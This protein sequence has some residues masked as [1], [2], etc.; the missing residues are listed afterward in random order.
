MTDSA[1]AIDGYAAALIEIAR[2]EGDV[3]GI[4]DEIYRAASAVA[5]NAELRDTLADPQVP[6][7]RK[8][9]IVEDL[10]GPRTSSSTVAAIGMLVGAGQ[11]VHLTDIVSRMVELAAEREGAVVAEVRSA[12]VLDDDQIA[13]LEAAL[14]RATGRRVDAK[15]VVDD[16]VIGGLVAKIGDTVFDGTVRSRFDDMRERWA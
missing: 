16:A 3:D 7:G 6:A 5:A 1:T 13:R 9:G 2:A 4:T 15:V 14:S 10:L 11:T 8:Q 12:V